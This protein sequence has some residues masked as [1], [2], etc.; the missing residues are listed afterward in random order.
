MY[1]I[2][3]LDNL[4]TVEKM[5]STEYKDDFGVREFYFYPKTINKIIS[6]IPMDIINIASEYVA[7]YEN[8]IISGAN[9]TGHN[10]VESHTILVVYLN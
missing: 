5:T 4:I 2:V 8:S 9:L 3:C 7:I 1:S 10:Y 6:I